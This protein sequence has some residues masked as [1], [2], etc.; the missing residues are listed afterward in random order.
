M[1]ANSGGL[2]RPPGQNQSEQQPSPGQVSSLPAWVGSGVLGGAPENNRTFAKIIEEEDKLNRNI[3]EITLEK[4]TSED[5]SQNNS[6]RSLTFD[7]LGEL[8]FD[9][10]KIDPKDCL[11]FDYNT[12]RYDTKQYQAKSTSRP[13]CHICSIS[14]QEPQCKCKEAS[15]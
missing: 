9:I 13:V 2:N 8:I 6:Q 12:A 7:D 3:L 15:E 10:I 4:H 14:L 11:A 5:E 1:S